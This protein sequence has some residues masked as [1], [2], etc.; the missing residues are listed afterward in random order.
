VGSSWRAS[1]VNRK[2]WNHMS[3]SKL[4]GKSYDIPKSL[5]WLC[6]ER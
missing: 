4:Q 1:V 6:P 5:V 3:E 2:G